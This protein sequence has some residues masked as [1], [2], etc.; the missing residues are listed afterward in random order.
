[1]LRVIQINQR[2][3]RGI[4][5]LETP[6]E[7]WDSTYQP[8]MTTILSSILSLCPLVTHIALI[9]PCND[10]HGSRWETNN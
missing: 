4:I 5:P 10:F 6:H 7:L 8:L 9:A 1:M 2:T 3:L